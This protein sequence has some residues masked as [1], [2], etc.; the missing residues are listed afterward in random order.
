MHHRVHIVGASG[1]GTSTLGR[2]LATRLES[3]QFDSDDFYWE[4]TDPPFTRK[5]P[6]AER[7]ELMRRMFA[8]RPDWVLSGSCVGWGDPL[9]ERFTH[10]VFLTLPAGPRLAR[11]R[12]RERRRYGDAIGPGGDQAER[13]RGFLD[14]AMGYDDDTFQGRSRKMHESWLDRLPCPVIRLDAAQPVPA[15]VE[16]AVAALDGARASA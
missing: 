5:R 15:L 14:W 12:A 7:M 8:P 1:T 16:A 9:I 2:A 4:P 11:L 13:F 6:P 3:Q 10:V